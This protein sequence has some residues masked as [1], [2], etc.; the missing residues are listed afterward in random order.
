MQFISSLHTVA[1]LRIYLALLLMHECITS[2]S[3]LFS[4][5]GK[6]KLNVIIIIYSTRTGSR[7]SLRKVG[8]VMLF[9][10]KWKPSQWKL[11]L[12]MATK[13]SGAPLCRW[14]IMRIRMLHRNKNVLCTRVITGTGITTNNECAERCVQTTRAATDCSWLCPSRSVAS[15]DLVCGALRHRCA[16]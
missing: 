2:V 1:R 16:P 8:N 5:A 15:D 6:F 10:R 3:H 9:V 7:L 14:E 11:W 4:F 12:V 13:Y